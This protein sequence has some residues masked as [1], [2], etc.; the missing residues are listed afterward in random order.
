MSTPQEK[1]MDTKATEHQDPL[2]EEVH[3]LMDYAAENGLLATEDPEVRKRMQ[4]TLL[5][6]LAQTVTEYQEA[7]D[8]DKWDKRTEILM[9]Y[10]QLARLTGPVTGRSLIDTKHIRHYVWP[11]F[12][13]IYVF[14]FLALI[15]EG[16]NLWIRDI[17]EPEEGIRLWLV[18]AQRYLLDNLSPLFWGGLG[19][20]VFLLKRLSDEARERRFDHRLLQ[21]MH[22][23]VWL[24]AI[25]GLVV[26]FLYDEE[27]FGAEAI[28][29]DA[30]AIAFF[31]GVGVK[32]VY[33]A[34]E[35]TIEQLAEKFNFAAIRRARTEEGPIRAYIEQQLAQ[36][37]P[38][39]QPDRRKVL[40][41][42]LDGL[43]RT[44][45]G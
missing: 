17:I 42:I 7:A 4:D 3:A 36:T 9:H 33:G 38:E 11:L 44:R 41:E 15:N 16:F 27:T 31:T 37:D 2:V 20:C 43:T 6:P 23:R 32:L 10:A 34:I 1:P 14:L 39:K 18:Q 12:V 26:I 25:L 29:L 28:N 21:G 13:Y 35:K 30:K 40:L 45:S 24:G 8:A 22:I 19:S 5:K